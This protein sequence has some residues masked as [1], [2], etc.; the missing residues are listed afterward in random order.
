MVKSIET[1]LIT[2][3]S[4]LVL[5]IS[6]LTYHELYKKRVL[7]KISDSFDEGD[8]TFQLQKHRI[9]VQEKKYWVEREQ[10]K[11][12]DDVVTGKI[13][14]RYLLLVGEKGVGKTSSI[15]ESIRKVNEVQGIL[16]LY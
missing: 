7:D 11:F 13:T 9:S 12:L 4:L 6:G 14:G 5:A 10:Q 2:F 1:G 15:M 3:S 16:L 8:P